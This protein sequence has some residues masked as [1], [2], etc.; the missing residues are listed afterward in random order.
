[1]SNAQLN[2]LVKKAKSEQEKRVDNNNLKTKKQHSSPFRRVKVEDWNDFKGIKDNSYYG[3]H[4]DQGWGAKAN[5]TLLLYKGKDF[6][7]Q[8]IKKKKGN[9]KGGKIDVNCIKSIKF[10]S[11]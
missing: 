4:G 8:K 2:K 10:D 7:H 3:N 9:Y 1:M 11:E 6:K 5:A